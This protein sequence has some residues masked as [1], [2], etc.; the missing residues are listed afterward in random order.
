MSMPK[1]SPIL[2][3]L[4][5]VRGYLASIPSTCSLLIARIRSASRIICCEHCCARCAEMSSPISLKTE[6]EPLAAGYP[7]SASIPA[8][9]TQIRPARR[10]NNSSAMGLRHTFAWHTINTLEIIRLSAEYLVSVERTVLDIE[11]TLIS[12]PDRKFRY[13][14]STAC[15]GNL[16]CYEKS[17][18]TG[19]YDCACNG[20]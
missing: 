19:G 18:R 11:C 10:R 20:E 14:N 8:E 15:S 6:I 2:K 13:P 4:P 12:V 5:R 1:L 17:C 9:T 3:I 7:T 16:S